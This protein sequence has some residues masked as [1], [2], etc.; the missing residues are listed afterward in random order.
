MAA[1]QAPPSL[2]FSRQEHWSGV[3]L[4]SPKECISY[5]LFC[6]KSYPP[7][8]VV[9]KNSHVLVYSSLE[10]Q[11]CE[12]SDS[13]EQ[14]FCWFLLSH[15]CGISQRHWH[16]RASLT[17]LSVGTASW[18]SSPTQHASHFRCYTKLLWLVVT[19]RQEG[20]KVS[21][22]STTSNP[23]IQVLWI[24]PVMLLLLLSRFSCVQLCADPIDGS[25][26][27]SSV[28]GILQARIME[29]VATFFSNAC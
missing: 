17:H 21:L 3:P 7:K 2:G 18:A 28:P 20:K 13:A 1:H 25:P 15:M 5:P 22:E 14:N 12:H 9:Y 24:M 19:G 4:P 16:A 27:G 10:R 23:Q 29:Q 11:F 6:N 8:I 26:P